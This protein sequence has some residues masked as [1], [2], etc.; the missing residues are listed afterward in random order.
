MSEFNRW[1]PTDDIL[2]FLELVS[3]TGQGVPGMTPE[4]AIKRMKATH[5]GPL[6]GYYWNGTMFQNTPVWL[7]LVEV[8]GV[9]CP[10]LYQYW[11]AQS[12]IGAETTYLVYYRHQVD[13][14]G[15]TVEEIIITSELYLPAGSPVVPVLPGDTVMGKLQ[16][17]ED[18]TMPVA[19]ANADAVWDEMLGQHLLPGSTG[20][21][22]NK[23]A[24]GLVGAYQITLA[25][26]DTLAVALQGVR[27]DIFDALGTG[28]LGR[29]WTAIGGAVNVALDA[30]TYQLRLFKSGYSFTVPELLTVS[31]D[32]TA[33]FIGTN[34]MVI[35]PPSDPNL[36][37]IYGVVR[38]IAGQPVPN[39]R[40]TA[41]A[42]TPQI[43][44]GTQQHS[45]IAC[46][47]TD[48]TGFFR[49]E[50]ERLALVNF[51]IEDTNL[52]V[53]RTVPDAP[54]QDLATW[55]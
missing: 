42:T 30:G 46:T 24:A 28:F 26:V 16:A 47:L 21:A 36:C 31:A 22:L 20:E 51:A 10:G 2:L 52:D 55:T 4:I 11:F 8:D 18:P 27:I 19:L 33:T 9:N 6:D 40:V 48:G 17:M 12:A 37:A 39:A 1:A 25:V 53:E 29:V 15:F 49:M 54:T 35:V 3:P 44:Q 45:E 5:G 43:I 13:P 23:L 32:A 41:Y 38:N 34:L 50:L 14:V 7:P